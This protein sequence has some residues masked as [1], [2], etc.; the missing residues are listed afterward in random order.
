MLLHLF[1]RQNLNSQID[2]V[3]DEKRHVFDKQI[4][5]NE[6]IFSELNLNGDSLLD[7]VCLVAFRWHQLSGR[8][9]SAWSR[10]FGFPDYGIAHDDE[11]TTFTEFSLDTPLSALAQFVE[12]ATQRLFIAFDS[13]EIPKSTTEDLVQRLIE[14][15]LNF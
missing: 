15:R 4:I 3:A 9:L 13:A 8:H 5:G 7:G 11:V 10:Q 2:H 6:S 1:N 12:E 14:R